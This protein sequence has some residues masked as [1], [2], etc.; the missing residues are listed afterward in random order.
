M[1]KFEEV[2]RFTKSLNVLFVEDDKVLRSEVGA[3]LEDFFESV[4][5]AMDG[6]E[7]LIRYKEFLNTRG[8]PFDVVITDIEMP[9]E[10]GIMLIE[11][12]VEISPEQPIIVVSAHSISHYLLDCINLGVAQF[13]KKPIL[14]DEFLDVVKKVSKR[15][16]DRS[17]MI[18][19]NRQ[20][21]TLSQGLEWNINEK[22][23]IHN[24][25]MLVL[26]HNEQILMEFLIE[27]MGYIC[28][29]EEIIEVMQ[30]YDIDANGDSIRNVMSRLRKKL[31]YDV[32]KS[33][34]GK[35]YKLMQMK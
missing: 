33:V 17:D 35:G 30:R 4:T 14:L 18:Q 32:V 24:H 2:Y 20:K 28:S 27:R 19:H 8:T 9:N 29:I 11:N 5:Y 13:I 25:S 34:Y 16:H 6:K 10:N 26:T 7:G 23:L 22:R 31:P 15:V 21:I 3:V 1:D 12:I